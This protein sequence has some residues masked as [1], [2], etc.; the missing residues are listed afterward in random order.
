MM[1]TPKVHTRTK[2]DY[3]MSHCNHYSNFD[4]KVNGGRALNHRQ[5]EIE[6]LKSLPLFLQ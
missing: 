4:F 5:H 2:E 3:Q 1:P 6:T